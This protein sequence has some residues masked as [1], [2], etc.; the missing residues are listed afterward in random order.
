MKKSAI[1]IILTTFISNMA[2]AEMD[3]KRQKPDIDAII[4]EIKLDSS[5]VEKF[6]AILEE[7]KQAMQ[8]KREQ[9]REKKQEMSR[10]QRMEARKDMEAQRDAM[11]E[12]LL[13]VLNYEQL[14]KF[15]KY[16]RQ[17]HKKNM[18]MRKDRQKDK[19]KDRQKPEQGESRN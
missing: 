1:F 3:E 2:L 5:K 19:G 10:E 13:T 8:T 18:E 14:Y 6:K 17:F 7:Q 9:R 15:K 4:A 11:D 16:M 12:K